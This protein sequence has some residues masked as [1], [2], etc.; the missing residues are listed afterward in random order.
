MFA[1]ALCLIFDVSED[2]RSFLE[3]VPFPNLEFQQTIVKCLAADF[4]I[5]FGIEK[6]MKHL[7]LR[8][9]RK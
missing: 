6:L 5:C 3:L 7:Y 8:Q 2:L 1:G 9:F 4:V